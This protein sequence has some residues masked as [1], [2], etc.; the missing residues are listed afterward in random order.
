MMGIPEELHELEYTHP[1]IDSIRNLFQLYIVGTELK[2][3]SSITDPDL[4]NI[5]NTLADEKIS[6]EFL[7]IFNLANLEKSSRDNSFNITDIFERKIDKSPNQTFL[8]ESLNLRIKERKSYSFKR[9][10]SKFFKGIFRI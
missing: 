6:E 7:E 4:I 1:S 10:L 3:R 2:Y 8:I 5:L 9:Y